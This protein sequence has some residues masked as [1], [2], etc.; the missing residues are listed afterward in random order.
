[1]AADEPPEPGFSLK[2]W[3]RRKLAAARAAQAPAG[4]AQPVPPATPPAIPVPPPAEPPAAATDAPPAPPL[5]P[6]ETLTFDSDF[7]AYLQP[8]VEEALRRQ[9]LRK[10]FRDP[11]FNVMDGLDVYID[12]YSLPDPV[13]PE[14]LKEMVHARY[15]F[16]PP[17]TRIGADG[18]VEDVPAED[19]AAAAAVDAAVEGAEP[20]VPAT[21]VDPGTGD[22][23]DAP[24]P[25][26]EPAAAADLPVPGPARA[27]AV[28]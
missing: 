27:P 22:A 5:P 21:A 19:V 3:S 10:L 23:A 14:L 9:A 24:A 6:V 4:A 11:R 15:V 7:T 16:D 8:K 1:M 18:F 25:A 12:D 13:S 26:V 20:A 2:R 28:R 17:A